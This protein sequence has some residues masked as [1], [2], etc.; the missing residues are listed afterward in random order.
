MG[1]QSFGGKVPDTDTKDNL[2]NLFKDEAWWDHFA[3]LSE[4]FGFSL[5]IFSS[6]GTPIFVPTGTIPP[7]QEFCS[8]SA[9]FNAKHEAFCHPLIMN[10]LAT[11]KPDIFKCYAKIMCFALPIRYMDEKAVILGQ[12]SFSS[13]EDFRECVNLL[14]TTG[15]DKISVTVPLSF[16]NY[17]QAWKVCGFV[18][19]SVNKLLQNTQ[20]NISLKRKIESLKMIIGMWGASVEERPESMYRNMIGKLSSLLDIDCITILVF[21]HAQRKYT[22]LYSLLRSKG[23]PEVYSINEDDAV[24]QELSA[25]KEFVL[26]AEPIVDPRADFLRGMGALYFFPILVN[27]KLVAIV[28]I[29]DR[30]LKEADR[31]VITAFCRNAALSIENYQLQQELYRKF[32]QFAVI[33]ELTK[34]ITPIHD[35]EKLLQAILDMSAELLKA[36]QG[37]LMLIDYETDALL[38]EAKKGIIDGVAEKLRINWGEGI[39]GKVAQSGEPILVENLENDPRIL[40][41]NR[42][43]YKTRSFVSIPLKIDDRI[44]GVL[45]LSDKSTGEVFNKEDLKLIQS[46][47]THA[48]VIME[49]NVFINKTEELKKLTITDALTGLLNRRYLHERLKDELARSARHGHTFGLL[50]LD[51][52][53]FKHCNDTLGH[54]F[55]DKVLKAMADTLLNVVRSIDIV[56][57]YGGDEFMIILP[58]T[59]KSVAI[60]IAERIL[61]NVSEKVVHVS[62]APGSRSYS[63]TTSIGIACYPEHG[64]SV[65]VLLENVDK[66]LYRAKHEGKN[67]VE[68]FTKHAI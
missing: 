67:R 29:D 4:S 32:D 11:G 19:I 20:E 54:P 8:S 65:E 12:G 9:E 39:A 5:S 48:A 51:L 1:M 55:G 57:R 43:H 35:Y 24:V 59:V 34:S 66:A 2:Q 61:S 45:N 68:V 13:Y 3:S 56:A 42:R 23:T 44:I 41:M 64:K 10:T 40:Q 36:E 60:E 18:A 31:Q 21:D 33:S 17:Q 14:Q 26:S 16:T 37:S 62:D 27:K 22:S 15:N 63:M 46:F 38:L 30:G 52:D 58:E 25:G 50:M 6:S 28:R 7:C 49:R 53:G 47:A